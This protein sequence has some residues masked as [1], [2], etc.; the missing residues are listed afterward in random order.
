MALPRPDPISGSFLAP[1]IRKTMA[2]MITSSWVPNPNKF[3]TSL[4]HLYVI[5]VFLGDF[6]KG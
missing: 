3:L 5:I 6:S 1:K 4:E 2:R